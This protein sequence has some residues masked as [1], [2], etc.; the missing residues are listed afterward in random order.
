MLIDMITISFILFGLFIMTFTI[1][2]VTILVLLFKFMTKIN[3]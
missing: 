2:F 1:F 3:R